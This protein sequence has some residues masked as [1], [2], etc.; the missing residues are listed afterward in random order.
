MFKRL[1][2]LFRYIEFAWIMRQLPL[3]DLLEIRREMWR[4]KAE[5][6]GTD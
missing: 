1:K 4:M 3:A 2:A 5:H 6:D